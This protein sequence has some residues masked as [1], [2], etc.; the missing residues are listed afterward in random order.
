MSEI[1]WIYKLFVGTKTRLRRCY[2]SKLNKLKFR[3]YGISFGNGLSVVG[4]IYVYRGGGGKVSIG[5]NFRVTSGLGLNPLARNI[6]FMLHIKRDASLTIGNNV[7]ISSSCIWAN[8]SIT[9]GNNVNVGAD[10]IIMDSDIHSLDF[11]QRRTPATDCANS[12]SA[13]IVIEDD[14]FIGTRCVIL[15]G[16]HIGARSIVAAGS[17]VTKNVPS[18]CIAGGN[19]CKVIKRFDK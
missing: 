3:L 16:V 8:E 14:A 1:N 18:D 7:G 19:P 2:Y 5:D 4:P 15:K 9:I 10:C 12:V 17:V 13:P 6:Q 11:M